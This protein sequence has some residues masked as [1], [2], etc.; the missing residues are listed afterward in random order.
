M[1]ND[2]L[3]ITNDAPEHVG[4]VTWLK[5]LEDGSREWYEKV[6]GEWEMVASEPSP[7]T[8]SDIATAIADHA[9]IAT[10]H[11]P[12][13]DGLTGSKTIGGY[14]LTFTAGLLTGF[15]VV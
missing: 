1:G 6:D 7:A 14:K 12:I 9:A 10:A 3:F 11:H 4:K 8:P 2:G 5:I 15:E 13:P